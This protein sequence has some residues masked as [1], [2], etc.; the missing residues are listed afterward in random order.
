M[1]TVD[2]ATAVQATAQPTATDDS[3]TSRTTINSDFETF[4]QMLTTQL[5]NQDPLNPVEATDFAVQLAT[6]A[7]VE[8]QV[9]TNELLTDVAGALAADSFTGLTAYGDWIGKE[10]LVAGPTYYDGAE[11]VTVEFSLPA[12]TQAADIVVYDVDGNEVSR[13]LITS[14][15]NEFTWD[16]TTTSGNGLPQGLYSFEV[17]IFEGGEVASNYTLEVYNT[18]EEVQLL[19]GKVLVV[20]E[21]G[22]L[23]YSDVVVGLR[24]SQA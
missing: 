1:T 13:S 4:L 5:E 7:N 14:S 10:A 16:G 24:D 12:G 23:A 9:L 2:S 21:G 15:A 18:V 3:V 19:D 6:F 17:E 20:M 8:Q 11:P 22:A